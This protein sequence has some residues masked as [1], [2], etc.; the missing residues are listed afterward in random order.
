[1]KP[2]SEL[3]KHACRAGLCMVV[4][5]FRNYRLVGCTRVLQPRV[6]SSQSWC[7]KNAVEADIM[8][9]QGHRECPHSTLSNLVV[10]YS[11]VGSC[12]GA[13][14]KARR[15]HYTNSQSLT[16]RKDAKLACQPSSRLHRTMQNITCTAINR[17]MVAHEDSGVAIPLE[18]GLAV[19][20]QK[21]SALYRFSRPHTMLGTFISVCSVS[22]LAVVRTTTD[23]TFFCHASVDVSKPEGAMLRNGSWERSPLIYLMHEMKYLICAGPQWVDSTSAG[24]LAPGA[25]PGSAHECVHCGPQSDF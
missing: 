21:L 14:W 22:A 10:T 19:V 25:H 16:A 2:G 20:P 6:F 8:A 18:E 24:G 11:I 17:Q 4:D 9:F 13:Q 7:P 5:T 3:L 23:D 12:A 1:M 15:R